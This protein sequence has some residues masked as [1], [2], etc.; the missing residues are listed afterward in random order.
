MSRKRLVRKEPGEEIPRDSYSRLLTVLTGPDFAVTAREH[1]KL[2]KPLVVETDFRKG[3][4]L[5]GSIELERFRGG[6]L[7]SSLI[8][9]LAV[10]HGSPP[11]RIHDITDLETSVEFPLVRVDQESVFSECAQDGFAFEQ[12]THLLLERG[13]V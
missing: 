12:R 11:F 13:Q 5:S 10:G 6:P 8:A 3:H 9:W 2:L 7:L 1:E 4:S